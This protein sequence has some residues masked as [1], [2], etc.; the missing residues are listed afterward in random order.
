MRHRIW[1]SNLG[2][3]VWETSALTTAPTLRGRGGGGWILVIIDFFD[4]YQRYTE[5]NVHKVVTTKGPIWRDVKLKLKVLVLQLLRTCQ[6]SPD[7]LTFL[8]DGRDFSHVNWKDIFSLRITFAQVV[9]KSVNRTLDSRTIKS[10]ST[11]LLA[12]ESRVCT[13]TQAGNS[14]SAAGRQ[15]LYD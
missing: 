10:S 7:D 11:T 1:E 13:V 9:D 2:H 8:H 14:L 4:I 5:N 3:I 6:F 15:R 12:C